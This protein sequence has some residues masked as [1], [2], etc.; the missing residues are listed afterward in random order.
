MLR[1][2]AVDARKVSPGDINV[3]L[4]SGADPDGV[5]VV[6]LLSAFPSAERD[7]VDALIRQVHKLLPHTQVVKVFCPGVTGSSESGESSGNN[8]PTV[9]SLAQVTD[10]CSS[11]QDVRSGGAPPHGAHLAA[12][13]RGG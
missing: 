8:Y 7:R 10:I 6:Y 13:V 11:W 1:T 3:G 2:Q 12:A 4:P 9:T 5:A